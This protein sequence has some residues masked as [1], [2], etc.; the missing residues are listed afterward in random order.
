[1]NTWVAGLTYPNILHNSAIFAINDFTSI[2]HTKNV[3]FQA[4]DL[5]IMEIIT[6]GTAENDAWENVFVVGTEKG[7][8]GA[9]VGSVV[10]ETG[11][12]GGQEFKVR[13]F[14]SFSPSS[15]RFQE[16]GVEETWIGWPRSCLT[17]M[18]PS[19]KKNK[20]QL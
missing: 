16:T 2:L 19:K 12:K 15:I 5:S 10:L 11:I 1:V 8:N 3:H 20:Y 14:D 7:I 6:N 4:P 13:I 18:K 17:L 9:R